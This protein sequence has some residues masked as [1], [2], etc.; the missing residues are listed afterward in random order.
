MSGKPSQDELHVQSHQVLLEKLTSSEA[1]L[2]FVIESL[3]EIVF[4]IDIA[5]HFTFLNP[6]W[7]EITGFS[8]E[9]SIGKKFFRYVY[10]EDIAECI[11]FLKAL[12]DGEK[13]NNR[14]EIRLLKKD[15][16]FCWVEANL[17]VT[18]AAPSSV[19]GIAGTLANI[20]ERIAAKESIERRDMIL[21]AVAFSAECFLK[22]D[23]V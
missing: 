8:V 7:E 22:G 19:S 4:Q 17:R 12:L 20:T 18:S 11:Y 16:G 15:G 10:P 23:M 13:E 9:E 5:G 21:E 2:R 1:R 3:N 14:Y 6:A